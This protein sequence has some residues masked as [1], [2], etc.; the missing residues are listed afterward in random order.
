MHR[1][2]VE[3]IPQPVVERKPE[4]ILVIS[5]FYST[6]R[7]PPRTVTGR[8]PAGRHLQRCSWLDDERKK[9][10]LGNNLR[11]SPSNNYLTRSVPRTQSAVARRLSEGNGSSPVASH[12]VVSPDPGSWSVPFLQN[13]HR[14]SRFEAKQ[15]DSSQWEHTTR[16][17]TRMPAELGCRTGKALPPRT[18]D[19]TVPLELDQRSPGIKTARHQTYSTG[20][21]RLANSHGRPSLGFLES[22]SNIIHQIPSTFCNYCHP[23]LVASRVLVAPWMTLQAGNTCM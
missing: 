4:S 14:G 5:I 2:Q 3:A 10:R 9:H 12:A 23:P 20:P 1:Q 11:T 22:L 19:T 7:R 13:R 15:A 21:G 16:L 17:W 18:W 8:L 6:R